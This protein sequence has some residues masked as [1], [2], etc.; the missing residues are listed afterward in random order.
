M[1]TE[2]KLNERVAQLI[3]EGEIPRK[4]II[5]GLI[6]EKLFEN[7]C[8]WFSYINGQSE[9]G[10][11]GSFPY[12]KVLDESRT[13]I[14]YNDL[15]NYWSEIKYAFNIVEK[16]KLTLTPSYD[17]WRV[18][19]SNTSGSTRDTNWVGTTNNQTWVKSE[20]IT[21]AICLAAL[22]ILKIKI[23]DEIIS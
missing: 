16:L 22:K 15:P 2:F 3:K 21:E 4:E 18:F 10:I 13:R 5:N 20:C 8:I 7:K 14:E 23:E 12:L 19:Q 1:Q 17:G 6:E 11:G 9:E